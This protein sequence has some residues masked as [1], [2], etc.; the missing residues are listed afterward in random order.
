VWLAFYAMGKIGV[1]HMSGIP[2][3]HNKKLIA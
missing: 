1:R 2:G 3:V